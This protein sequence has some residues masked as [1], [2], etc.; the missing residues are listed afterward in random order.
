M[1][2]SIGGEFVGILSGIMCVERIIRATSMSSSTATNFTSSLPLTGDHRTGGGG[3]LFGQK[4]EDIGEKE[5]E[6]EKKK[7]IFGMHDISEEDTI[8]INPDDTMVL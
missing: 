2:L 7:K 5:Q 3:F 8:R 6:E 1:E 4:K